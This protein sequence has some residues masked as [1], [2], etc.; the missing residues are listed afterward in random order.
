VAA[1]APAEE[2][3]RPVP[4][5]QRRRKPSEVSEDELHEALRAERWNLKATAAALGIARTSLYVLL[6]QSPRARAAADVSPEEIRRVHALCGGDLQAMV[7]ELQVSGR[8]LRQ[9]LKDLG[10]RLAPKGL[11]GS[12]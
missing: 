11:R 5:R 8:A 9:R 4:E 7:G 3:P 1:P 12:S 10:L 2:S 6:A